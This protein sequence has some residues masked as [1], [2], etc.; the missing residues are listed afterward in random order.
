MTDEELVLALA[1]GDEQATDQL[2]TR[3]YPSIDRSLCIVFGRRDDEYDDVFQTAFEQVILSIMNGRFN[4]RCR[5]TTWASAIASHV[6]IDAIRARQ[7]RRK[8]FTSKPDG[9]VHAPEPDDGLFEGQLEAR[10][11][12]LL[13]QQALA[14]ID[15]KKARILVLHQLEGHPVSEVAE[16]MGISYEACQSRLVRGRGQFLKELE[17]LERGVKS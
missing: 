9:N 2:Y 16:I 7:R 13:V 12:F 1:R 11:T 15:P 17:K 10:S 14:K 3:I 6:G 5:L 8:F 4:H